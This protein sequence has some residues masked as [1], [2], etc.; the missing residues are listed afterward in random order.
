[1]TG[2]EAV[3]SATQ[4]SA[5]RLAVANRLEQLAE[6]LRAI[7]GR[8]VRVRM[9][10]PNAAEEPPPATPA[11]EPGRPGAPPTVDRRAAA[12]LPLVRRVMD[13]FPDATITEVRNESD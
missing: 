9:L 7:L 8:R 11:G 13:T 2:D 4:Q 12:E 3:I 10:E 1:M 5:R 6:E